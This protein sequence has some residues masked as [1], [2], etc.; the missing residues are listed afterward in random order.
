VE[1]EVMMAY[2]RA[3]NANSPDYEPWTEFVSEDL[4]RQ[5]VKRY[6]VPS[7]Q[8]V[9]YVTGKLKTNFPDLANGGKPLFFFEYF[10][11]C[12]VV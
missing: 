5:V 11:P 4:V 12:V 7:H 3:N 6:K 8:F 10:G 1:I 9:R 2:A